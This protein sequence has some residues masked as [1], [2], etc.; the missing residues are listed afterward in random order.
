MST[1]PS[2]WTVATISTHY[3]N[4]GARTWGYYFSLEEAVSGMQRCVDTEAG[5]YR[6]AI[7]ENFTPGIYALAVT[8]DWYEWVNDAGWVPCSK[9]E[10]ERQ[11][12]NY[13]MG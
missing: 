6:Y 1:P 3:R 9:P 10:S 4:M 12:I 7:I 2:I 13:G 11:I 5:Y 8:E